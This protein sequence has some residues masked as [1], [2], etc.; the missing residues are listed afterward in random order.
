MYIECLPFSESDVHS[1]RKEDFGMC[2]DADKVLGCEALSHR[3]RQSWNVESSKLFG[4]F[5][6]TPKNV[7][8]VRDLFACPSRKFR[9]LVIS[10]C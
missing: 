7:V 4:K 1:I 9:D 8:G 2:G 6:V 10:S 5:S 3:L